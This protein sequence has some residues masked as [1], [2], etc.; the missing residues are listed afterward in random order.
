MCLWYKMSVFGVRPF[1]GCRAE[2]G[3]RYRFNRGWKEI[4][5][6]KEEMGGLLVNSVHLFAGIASLLSVFCAN[7]AYCYFTPGTATKVAASVVSSRQS[8][9]PVSSSI[10][11]ILPFDRNHWG[12][13]TL[14]DSTGV[15][16]A[17]PFPVLGRSTGRDSSYRQ[18]NPMLDPLKPFGNTPTGEYRI[19][20]FAPT[21][22]RRYDSKRFG[23]NFVI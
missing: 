20:G 12:S 18:V 17:G 2:S 14:V 22:N 8:G 3:V 1:A 9:T 11:I 13:L 5:L 19:D 10:V 6:I 15:A 21:N 4:A 16:L 7:G 23:K